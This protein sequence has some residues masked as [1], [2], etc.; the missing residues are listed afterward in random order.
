LHEAAVTQ[1]EEVRSA[2]GADQAHFDREVR[3]A[4]ERRVQPAD[5][6]PGT[7]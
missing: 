1:P 5:G 2:V 6:G 3:Q 7:W 4:E